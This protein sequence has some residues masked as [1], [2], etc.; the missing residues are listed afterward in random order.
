MQEKKEKGK[1]KTFLMYAIACDQAEALR[2]G[3]ESTIVL[4]TNLVF[5]HELASA[6]LV[7]AVVILNAHRCP[8]STVLQGVEVCFQ[9]A[10]EL[11]LQESTMP[12][13]KWS[14]LVRSTE[15]QL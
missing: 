4:V 9:A 3:L 15:L 6:G 7:V 10:E 5:M 14:D 2:P 11:N 1:R 12:E 8:V 13:G